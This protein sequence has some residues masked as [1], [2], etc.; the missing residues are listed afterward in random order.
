MKSCSN[1]IKLDIDKISKL[2]FEKQI[3][4]KEI[5]EKIDKDVSKTTVANRL[6]ENGFD[7]RTKGKL[8][9]DL[10][11]IKQLYINEE[12]PTTKIA[13]KLDKNVSAKTIRNRLKQT[14]IDLRS[15]KEA[16]KK[17]NTK[18]YV[19]Y[20]MNG[21]GY[22]IWNE[23]ITGNQVKVHRLVAVAE[24][25]FDAVKD[26]EVHH[27]NGIKWDNRPENLELLNH[28]QHMKKH[29]KYTEEEVLQDIR[30]AN[31]N[32]NGILTVDDYRVHGN[33]S[34]SIVKRYFGSWNEGRNQ[35]LNRNDSKGE[36]V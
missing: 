13:E 7:L 9:L 16:V 26:K 2:Y 27:K 8:K 14:D 36:N 12:L 31:D 35:A 18:P 15:Q 28:K 5:A 22:M 32:V 1:K 34:D 24:Y 4:T 17:A 29:R 10:E 25:G 30:Q 20:S 33:I 3:S 6:R 11:K 19:P 23:S 21:N